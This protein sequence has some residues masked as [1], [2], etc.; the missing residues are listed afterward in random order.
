[1][2]QY[3]KFVELSKRVEHDCGQD[4]ITL[5]NE[6]GL[7]ESQG[8]CLTVTKAMNLAWIAS[9]ATLHRRLDMLVETGYISHAF[10]AGNRRT[11][12]IITTPKAIKYFKEMEECLLHSTRK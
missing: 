5:L 9:P 3:M 10:K 11:K 12:L 7:A 1:M 8:A 2:N 4:C 6:I